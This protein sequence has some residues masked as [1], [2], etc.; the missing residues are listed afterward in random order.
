[1]RLAQLRVG[2]RTY[3][4]VGV[5]LFV[6][7]FAIDRLV[8]SAVFGR[9]WSPINYLIPTEAYTI[10]TLPPDDRFFYLVMLA[11]ALPF[12][13][14]GLVMTI[15]RLRD[16]RLSTVWAGLF[17][18]PV[19]NLL[20]FSMLSALRT[21]RVGRRIDAGKMDEEIAKGDPPL[22]SV[23]PPA[24]ESAIEYRAPGTPDALS[25]RWPARNTLSFMLSTLIAGALAPLFVLLGVM[26]LRNYGWGL[27]VGTPFVVG[28]VASVLHHLSGHKS[29]AASLSV[30]A[31]A[32]VLG[33]GLTIL[34]PLEALGCL[35]MLVP[36][37][38]PLV[39]VGG[40]V[41]HAV[42]EAGRGPALQS[43]AVML[44]A[45]SVLMA[46]SASP[47][48]RRRRSSPPAA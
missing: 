45:L 20:F 22:A 9:G 21:A 12:A 30:A 37:A 42:M 4:L 5:T 31:T 47:S 16:A 41:G 33:F 44:V 11:V 7:K 40:A 32:G 39:L 34:F 14:V 1:M 24:S 43:L 13:L 35:I 2:R 29:A 23:V 6:T 46:R 36:L 19:V 17:F 8:A 25:G 27:F 48:P 26:W 28:M 10:A 38:A 3:L 15:A 18:V